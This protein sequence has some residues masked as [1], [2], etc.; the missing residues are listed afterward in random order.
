MDI[1]L[2]HQAVETLETEA[3][4]VIVFEKENPFGPR[5]QQL[6]A[7]ALRGFLTPL[8]ESG[9]ITGKLYETA[10][11]HR[12]AGLRAKRLLVVG[13]GKLEKF[14]VS[15]LRRAAGVAVRTLKARS[16]AEVAFLPDGSAT[17]IK[18]VA[19]AVE[20]ALVADFD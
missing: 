8:V 5:L 19:A 16:L 1:R 11:F 14:G 17:E 4:V 6:N 12:P 15:E 9:D 7:S 3:L 13:G 20:G 18:A 10:L 2:V